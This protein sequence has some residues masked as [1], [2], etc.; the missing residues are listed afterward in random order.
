MLTEVLDWG[1]VIAGVAFVIGVTSLVWNWHHGRSL[2]RRRGLLALK[3]TNVRVQIGAVTEEIQE[4]KDGKPDEYWKIRVHISGDELSI[5]PHKEDDKH[6][7][8][9]GEA[10]M[11]WTSLARDLSQ[12]RGVEL[13]SKE[14]HAIQLS[15]S[16]GTLEIAGVHFSVWVKKA[17]DRT[18]YEAIGK[19]IVFR[20]QRFIQTRLSDYKLIKKGFE[21]Q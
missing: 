5:R 14:I 2:V 17:T 1:L 18:Q 4:D 7:I 16:D 11:A 12:S 6:Y 20:T 8:R 19:E 10:N 13:V 15:T 3:E 9:V 21:E